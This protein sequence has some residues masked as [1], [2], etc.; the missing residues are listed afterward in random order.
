MCPSQYRLDNYRLP[1]TFETSTSRTFVDHLKGR[2]RTQNGGSKEE[3]KVTLIVIVAIFFKCCKEISSSWGWKMTP[4]SHNED[5]RPDLA[6]LAA[7]RRRRA[8][9]NQS[10]ERT[11]ATLANQGKGNVL[12]KI[13]SARSETW[14]PRRNIQQQLTSQHGT[15]SHC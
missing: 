2:R 7:L 3:R 11:A 10:E 9:Q 4:G 1:R 14:E 6:A 15:V 13:T 8:S 12:G 5:I